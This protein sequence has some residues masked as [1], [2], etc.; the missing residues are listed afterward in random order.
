MEYKL[1]KLPVKT[2][3][4]FKINELDI[5]LDIPRDNNFKDIIIDGDT[6]KLII[7]KKEINKKIDSKIGLEF[8][9]Y[10][11]INITVPKDICLEENIILDF[12]LNKN[13]VL[14]DKININYLDNSKCNFIINYSSTFKCFQHLFLEVNA[15][16]N[17]FGNITLINDLDS[18]STN[19]IAYTSSL[20]NNSNITTNIIDI[21]GN[22]RVYNVYSNLIGDKSF[23]NLNNIYIGDNNNIIDMNYYLINKGVESHNE[24]IVNGTLND[25]SY[26]AFRGTI[27]FISGCSNSIGEENENCIL[28][29]DSCISKSLPQMLCGEENV[30]GTH[31]VSSGS[32]DKDK[33]FYIMSRGY[34]RKDAEKLIILANFNKILNNILDDKY[35]SIILEKI[36]DKLK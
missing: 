18:D 26:K 12:K 11:D 35:R 14:I 29:S 19:F 28:L 16:N 10:L 32:V 1:N 8:N 9:K 21:G 5:E 7:E 6:S 31:G 3:N 27:D 15:F 20:N 22:I 2:T 4:N 17:S 23:N 25:N 13:D 34:S 36:E 33:L 24:M 30:I